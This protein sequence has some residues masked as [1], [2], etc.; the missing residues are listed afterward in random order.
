M[1]KY[2]AAAIPYFF[3]FSF[4][5][6]G[7]PGAGVHEIKGTIAKQTIYFINAFVT[8]IIFTIFIDKKFI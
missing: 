3:S 7:R 1:R 4:Y 6:F 2:T 8:G 5:I